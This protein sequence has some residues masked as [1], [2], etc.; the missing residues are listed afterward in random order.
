MRIISATL[1]ALQLAGLCACA[2][3]E[4]AA[5]AT[6]PEQPARISRPSPESRAELLRAVNTAL[7]TSG[8][9]L[10]DDALTTSDKLIIER[11]PARDASG[12]RLSG[13]DFDRPQHFLLVKADRECVLVH[14]ESGQRFPLKDV[15]CEDLSK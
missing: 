14:Q 8:V 5:H 3:P 12:Q 10:A 4:L 1:F 11:V 13:R 7:H 9:T 6:G 15:D 2:N